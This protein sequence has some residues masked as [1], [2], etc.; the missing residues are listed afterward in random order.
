T[1]VDYPNDTLYKYTEHRL[2]GDIRFEITNGLAS[3]SSVAIGFRN[4]PHPLH[5]S[6]NPQNPNAKILVA[7]SKFTQLA[8]GTGII[9][10]TGRRT[11]LGL[12][13]KLTLNPNID[14]LALSASIN[15]ANKFAGPLSTNTYAYDKYGGI[16]SVQ[17]RLPLDIDIGFTFDYEHR[18]YPTFKAILRRNTSTRSDDMYFVSGTI[19]K[20][21]FFG[22]E[23]AIGVFT[24]VTPIIDLTYSKLSSSI[25]TFSYKDFTTALNISLDF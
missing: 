18:R 11:T 7:Q 3:V 9:F 12:F 22:S 15:Q 14:S 20:P 17:S 13:G 21:F 6:L 8:F 25:S 24:G 16:V 2:W 5:Q 23:R 1:S 4:N 19:A 10:S